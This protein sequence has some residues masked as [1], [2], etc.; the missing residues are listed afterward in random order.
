MGVQDN[1]PKYL[2]LAT[3]GLPNCPSGCASSTQLSQMCTMTDNPSED[4]LV[5]AAVTSALQQGFKTFV[6]G[7]GNV[8]TAVNTLNQL[9]ANGG[10]SQTGGTTSYYA[11]TDP[12]SL[13]KALNAIVGVV[14]CGLFIGRASAVIVAATDGIHVMN[15]P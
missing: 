5:E 8:A 9:A 15:A 6:I 14:D 11:A 13:Q 10:E 7:S 12:T 4:T 1:N 2:L 3:D